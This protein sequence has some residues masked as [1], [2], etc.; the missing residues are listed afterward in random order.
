MKTMNAMKITSPAVRRCLGGV[1]AATVIGGVMVTA[2]ATPSAPSA[3]AATDPCAASEVARTIG[4]VA[5]S[6]AIYLD[7]H[8]GTN[9]ALTTISQQQGGAQSLGALKTYFDANPQ[10]A[11]DMQGLQ[12]PLQGLSAQCK[13]PFTLPQVMG[14]L[15]GAQSPAGGL[16][17]SLP[18]AQSTAQS[19]GVPGTSLPAQSSPAAVATP[20]TGQLPGPATTTPR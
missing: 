11:K 12:A 17:G 9:N 14:L 7:A 8:P 19:V 16:A 4:S 18:G 2:M 1:F 13:L 5:T 3:T 15:Q 6:T 10:A 20:G